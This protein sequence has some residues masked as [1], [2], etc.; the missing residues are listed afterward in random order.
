MMEAEGVQYGLD[1]KPRPDD[2][3][4]LRFENWINIALQNTREQRPGIDL[5]DAIYFMSQLENGADISDLE[6]QLEYA[7]EKNKQ[8]AQ[9]NAVANM[10]AQ[11]QANAQAEQSKMQGELAKI[12]A[13]TEGKAKEELVRGQVKASNTKLEKNYE[14]LQKLHE[15]KL[16]EE[17]ILTGTGK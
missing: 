15:A 3:Q 16:K 8:E 9:K 4:K 1:L 7:I 14:F 12:Q 11:S 13:E 6:K 10:Q 2:K 17:G 5:N